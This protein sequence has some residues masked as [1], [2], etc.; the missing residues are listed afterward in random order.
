MSIYAAM[1][2]S[3]YG[4][5]RRIPIAD[6]RP[7]DRVWVPFL[8][9]SSTGATPSRSYVAMARETR[10]LYPAPVFMR[11]SDKSGARTL[12]HYWRKY[13]V[14]GPLVQERAS[15]VLVWREEWDD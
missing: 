12:V 13:A 6:V 7:G 10:G 4:Q 2:H 15:F 3:E 14:V 9:E 11:H 8:M 5:T 1:L